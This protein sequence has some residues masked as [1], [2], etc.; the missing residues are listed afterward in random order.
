M[1]REEQACQRRLRAGWARDGEAS[2]RGARRVC[3]RARAHHQPPAERGVAADERGPEGR[4]EPAAL[5]LRRVRRERLAQRA[6][7]RAADLVRI[8]AAAI[9]ASA[10]ACAG[11]QPRGRERAQVEAQRVGGE[12][13][14]HAVLGRAA[15]KAEQPR[16]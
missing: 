13:E 8:V 3:Q 14:H 2:R 9:A 10:S 11:Q 5:F 1:C 6:H 15:R 7:N 4:V 16:E 12:R